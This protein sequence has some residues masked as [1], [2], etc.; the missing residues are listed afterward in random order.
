MN[1]HCS[2]SSKEKDMQCASHPSQ[3]SNVHHIALAGQQVS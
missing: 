3:S 2:D 1:A